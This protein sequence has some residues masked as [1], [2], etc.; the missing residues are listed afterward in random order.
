MAEK[1]RKCRS[2]AISTSRRPGRPCVTSVTHVIFIKLMSA[3]SMLIT[4]Q[5]VSA[6]AVGV[7]NNDLFFFL[8]IQLFIANSNGLWTNTIYRHAC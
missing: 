5:P 7:K 4:I 2:F 6:T 8:F 3:I 1:E